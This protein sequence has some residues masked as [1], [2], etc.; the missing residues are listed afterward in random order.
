MAEKPFF[1]V[2]AYK[3]TVTGIFLGNLIIKLKNIYIFIAKT[4]K[5]ALQIMSYCGI[6]FTC[7]ESAYIAGWLSK[8]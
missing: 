5:F 7:N 8:A 1:S 6:I 2:S 3:S 4:L